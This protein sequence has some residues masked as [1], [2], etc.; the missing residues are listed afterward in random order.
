MLTLCED[1]SVPSHASLLPGNFCIEQWRKQTIR[2]DIRK[3]ICWNMAHKCWSRNSFLVL[4]KHLVFF[5]FQFVLTCLHYQQSGVFLINC[6]SSC[7]LFFHLPYQIPDRPISF[8]LTVAVPHQ[9][10]LNC[11]EIGLVRLYI[12]YQL[13]ALIIIYS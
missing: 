5:F 8:K 1:I 12:N 13:D 9:I 10:L 2:V 11:F 7:H 4:R 6:V 3:G